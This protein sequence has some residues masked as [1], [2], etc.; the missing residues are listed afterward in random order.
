MTIEKAQAV[1][2]KHLR[3][4]DY[5]IIDKNLPISQKDA[6]ASGVH[7]VAWDR[8]TDEM[9]FVVVRAHEFPAKS[10]TSPTKARRE[11]YKK[12]A[13]NWCRVQRWQQKRTRFDA[14]E[15]YGKED[16]GRPVIDHITNIKV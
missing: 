11:L 1:A 2:V 3:R 4:F 8:R 10:V 16:G 14:V 12:A 6:R 9:V 7:L 15:V 13:R 5:E